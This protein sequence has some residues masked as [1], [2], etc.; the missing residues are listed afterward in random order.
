MSDLGS[1]L[2][3]WLKQV[4]S[5]VPPFCVEIFLKDNRS[6]FLHSVTLWEDSDP[7]AVVRIW[8]LRDMS[9]RE[10]QK[11][12]EALSKVKDRKEFGSPESIYPKLDWA[13]LRI[14][15]ENVAYV[16][17]W[18]DRLLEPQGKIGF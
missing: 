4:D 1:H 17:E 16:I 10:I 13:N 11:V 14:P 5:I 15:K 12:K 8:D 18:H 7:V 3:D 2:K 9:N 6:Y